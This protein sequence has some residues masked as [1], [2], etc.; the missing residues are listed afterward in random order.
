[1]GDFLFTSRAW[2][3]YL[4]WQTQDKKTL[5]RINT[6]LRDIERPGFRFKHFQG[7]VQRLICFAVHH[8]AANHQ[9]GDFFC[10]GNHSFAMFFVQCG[11]TSQHFPYLPTQK[12]ASSLFSAE[13]IGHF[14]IEA[15]P[16]TEIVQQIGIFLKAI[17]CDPL[18]RMIK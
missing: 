7:N 15:S 11:I 12:L 6:L 17:A 9:L 18:P 2:S 13:Q 3:D 16:F 8:R 1:M 10:K 5:K 4:Y 14:I